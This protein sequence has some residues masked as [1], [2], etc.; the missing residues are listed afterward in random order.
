M[1]AEKIQLR[2]FILKHLCRTKCCRM[3]MDWRQD[4]ARDE[5]KTSHW[6]KHSSSFLLSPCWWILAPII[7]SLPPGQCSMGQTNYIMA[8]QDGHHAM[9]P[10][11]CTKHS[12]PL[13]CLIHRYLNISFLSLLSLAHPRSK[14][15][16]F[17][18]K[19]TLFLL[20][21]SDLVQENKACKCKLGRIIINNIFLSPGN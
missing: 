21:L 6:Y 3:Q 14:K 10:L 15:C 8:T 2:M 12:N 18:L 11:F 7:S 16:Y 17:G 4:N 5:P 9:K 1:A 13:Q 19:K 20:N